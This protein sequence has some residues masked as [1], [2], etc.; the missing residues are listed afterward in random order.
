MSSIVKLIELPFTNSRMSL[1]IF[2][3]SIKLSLE[4]LFLSIITFIPFGLKSFVTK[5]TVDTPTFQIFAN[6]S[7]RTYLL[8]FSRQCLALFSGSV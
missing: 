1:Q 4:S 2:I 3:S 5:Y 7:D 8:L 6:P